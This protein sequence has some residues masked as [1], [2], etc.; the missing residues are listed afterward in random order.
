M[1]ATGT[2][3]TENVAR[4]VRRRRIHGGPE[5]LRKFDCVSKYR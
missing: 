5:H 4:I 1:A 3:V 2:I